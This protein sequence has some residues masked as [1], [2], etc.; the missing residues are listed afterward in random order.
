[1]NIKSSS[2]LV[3]GTI[4]ELATA[5]VL[6]SV[7]KV[8]MGPPIIISL[9]AT[10]TSL[11]WVANGFSTQARN[12]VLASLPLE[13]EKSKGK[14]QPFKAGLESVAHTFCIIN[15]LKRNRERYFLRMK[16]N[17]LS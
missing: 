8:A 17:A 1:M 10:I 14:D 12:L 7:V 11:Y 13:T 6:H 15:L 5:S 9:A 3:G 4:G 16:G 2:L